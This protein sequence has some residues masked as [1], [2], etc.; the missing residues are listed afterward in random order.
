MLASTL[1]AGSTTGL[2]GNGFALGLKSG[3]ACR[4]ATSDQ[5]KDRCDFIVDDSAGW[6][7]NLTIT[8]EFHLDIC[9]PMSNSTSNWTASAASFPWTPY[10]VAEDLYI[11]LQELVDSSWWICEQGD[12]LGTSEGLYVQCNVETLVSN[13]SHFRSIWN[14]YENIWT[15]VKQSFCESRCPDVPNSSLCQQ[16][17][18]TNFNIRSW[19]IFNWEIP[20]QMAYQAPC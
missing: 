18:I 6:K 7:R 17:H 11:G 1:E 9:L 12:C 5:V 14:E 4:A 10:T 15:I 19:A 20:R 8:G 3:T 16:L 13:G 2:A